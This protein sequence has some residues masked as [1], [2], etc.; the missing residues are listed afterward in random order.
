MN[1]VYW[2]H[3][4]ESIGD[5]C[6]HHNVKYTLLKGKIKC[7]EIILRMRTFPTTYSNYLLKEIILIF[8]SVISKYVMSNC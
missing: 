4:H 8:N 2:I 3:I 1:I 6:L 5:I 7:N